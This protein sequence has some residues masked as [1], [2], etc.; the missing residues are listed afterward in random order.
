[1]L[2]RGAL[3]VLL[4]A[5]LTVPVAAS[6]HEAST[7]KKK[8]SYCSGVAK[9]QKARGVGKV[10]SQK[11]FLFTNKRKNEYLY[12]GE[13]PKRYGSI[14]SSDG[15]AVTSQL[16][17]V[18]GNCALFYSETKPGVAFS[19]GQKWLRMLSYATLAKRSTSSIQRRIGLKDDVVKP[20]AST[21]S[22][23]CVYA[24]T[25]RVNGVPRLVVDGI[26]RYASFDE[27]R[28]FELTSASDSELRSVKVKPG[29]RGTATISWTQGGVANSHT[30]LG[31]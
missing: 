15:I 24:A 26:G 29:A 14:S 8:R 3:L 22:K 17:A 4:G 23:N 6:A 28:E 5:L 11:F 7:A 16:R 20:I 31:K 25:Y 19:A 10:K 13:S 2:A 21:L 12:C 27:F 30:I 18:K 9:K 1:M